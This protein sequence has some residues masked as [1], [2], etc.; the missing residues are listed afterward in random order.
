MSDSAAPSPNSPEARRAERERLK[1]QYKQDLK[2]AKAMREEARRA[3]DLGRLASAMEQVNEAASMGDTDDWIRRLNEETARNEARVD[4]ALEAQTPEAAL[5]RY[6]AQEA[7]PPA[8]A[9]D[10]EANAEERTLGAGIS[11][12][13]TPSKAP[14]PQAASRTL[15]NEEA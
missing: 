4:L 7:S 5:A 9:A 1:Q 12:D 3:R 2:A 8:P 6:R 14:N 15:G 11:E 13:A 10:E